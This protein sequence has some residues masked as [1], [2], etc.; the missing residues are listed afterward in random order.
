MLF[1]YAQKNDPDTPLKFVE[2]RRLL[3]SKNKVN[4]S[5]KSVDDEDYLKQVI[6]KAE[7]EAKSAKE[8]ALAAENANEEADKCANSQTKTDR[9]NPVC[10]N[11]SNTPTIVIG[12]NGYK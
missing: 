1:A 11:Q 12:S 8:A 10:Y 2:L 5:T 4:P 6:V 7:E 3:N 9:G